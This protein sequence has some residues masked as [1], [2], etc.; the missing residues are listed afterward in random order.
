MENKKI[1]RVYVLGNRNLFVETDDINDAIN[2]AIEHANSS[3]NSMEIR[4]VKG[5]KTYFVIGITPY[6]KHRFAY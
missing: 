2:M 6:K 3:K 4:E 1:F 5:K